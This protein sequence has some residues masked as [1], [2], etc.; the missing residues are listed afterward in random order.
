[1]DTDRYL[2]IRKKL[3][4]IEGMIKDVNYQMQ[5]LREAIRGAP[6]STPELPVSE[7]NQ[8]SWWPHQRS[9]PISS[10]NYFW[11]KTKISGSVN[12]DKTRSS[13]SRRTQAAQSSQD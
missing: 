9:G 5:E 3:D 11:D 10:R 4:D 6:L 7:P 12:L 1:M 2:K 13:I 8:Y